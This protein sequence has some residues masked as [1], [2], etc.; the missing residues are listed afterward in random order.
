MTPKDAVNE[1]RRRMNEKT[2]GQERIVDRFVM[3]LLAGGNVL[4]EGLPGLAKTQ[5]VRAMS[6]II[7]AKFSRIRITSYNV[8]YTKLL[9]IRNRPSS[10]KR[11]SNERDRSS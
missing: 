4:V 11:W 5:T 8:C 2:I 1:L 6:E 7:D 10:G 3:G 9:R